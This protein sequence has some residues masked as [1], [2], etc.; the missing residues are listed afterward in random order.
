MNNTMILTTL[1]ILGLVLE[2]PDI[3]KTNGIA[4]SSQQEAQFV[5]Q[6]FCFVF[7]TFTTQ[8]I[9][10]ADYTYCKREKGCSEL[11]SG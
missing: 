5:V 1:I 9:V 2:A 6:R 8:L 7:T 11:T 4:I 10:A 3:S